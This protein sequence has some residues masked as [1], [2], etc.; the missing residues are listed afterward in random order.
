MRAAIRSLTSAESESRE[1][2]RFVVDEHQSSQNGH[3]VNAS[4]ASESAYTSHGSAIRARDVA[5]PLCKRQQRLCPQTTT[6]IIGRVLIASAAAAAAAADP[7][8]AA[9]VQY[10]RHL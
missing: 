6:F 4:P 5:V 7:A 3:Y 8:A 10:R 9:A 2:V 1:A